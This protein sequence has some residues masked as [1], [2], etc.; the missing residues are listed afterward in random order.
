M[1]TTIFVCLFLCMTKA[2][3]S[4]LSRIFDDDSV[5]MSRDNRDTFGDNRDNQRLNLS[6]A[7]DAPATISGAMPRRQMTDTIADGQGSVAPVA[8][9]TS[10]PDTT[11]RRKGGAM[12]DD[13]IEG[14]ATDSVVFDARN[15]MIY[16]YRG[17]DVTYQGMN[18]KADYMSVN[19]ET[20]DIFAHG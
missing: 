18:L 10:K 12:F 1:L 13:I 20:K 15:K 8:T 17:G 4:T 6:S 7:I 11:Q 2:G 3:A 9:A 16:S 19:M 5:A 14:K